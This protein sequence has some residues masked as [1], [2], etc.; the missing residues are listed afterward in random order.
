MEMT[1]LKLSKIL[2]T[3]GFP[4]LFDSQVDGEII[5][6]SAMTGSVL[7]G[8]GDRVV[9]FKVVKLNKDETEIIVDFDEEK[10]RLE[11]I[12]PEEYMEVLEEKIEENLEEIHYF[13]F[14]V[15]CQCLRNPEKFV[16]LDNELWGR[17]FVKK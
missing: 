16:I 2:E 6:S 1:L 4:D 8:F 10:Y 7:D 12:N 13:D 5:S 9:E 15:F 11:L 14:D 3:A 17:K